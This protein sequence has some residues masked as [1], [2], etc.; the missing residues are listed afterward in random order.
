MTHAIT[1]TEEEYRNLLLLTCIAEAVISGEE[2]S[3][4]AE[5]MARYIYSQAEKFNCT[6]WV[7]R[8]MG[9]SI[10]TG[11][12]D[13]LTRDALVNYHDSVLDHYLSFRLAQRD[14]EAAGKM[15]EE[16]KDAAQQKFMG[17]YQDEFSANGFRNL[18]IVLRSP[19]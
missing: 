12:L 15:S 10:P 7:G 6:D 8:K 2:G 5:D 9:N 18:E 3:E 1:F 19:E 14:V 16:E 11:Q 4:N 13:E 17:K